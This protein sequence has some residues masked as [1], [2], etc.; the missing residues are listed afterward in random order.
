M[1]N[2]SLL[3]NVEQGNLKAVEVLL[4]SGV[5]ASQKNK[6]GQSLIQVAFEKMLELQYSDKLSFHKYQKIFNLLCQYGDEN[7]KKPSIHL[8]IDGYGLL[9]RYVEALKQN[10]DIDWQEFHEKTKECEDV[11]NSAITPETSPF[12]FELMKKNPCLAL[13]ASGKS[14][15]LIEGERGNSQTGHRMH[16]AG[17]VIESL[18]AR[19]DHDMNDNNFIKDDLK[20]KLL[21][22]KRSGKTLHLTGLFS[23]GRIHADAKHLIYIANKANEMGIKVKAHLI[24]DGTDSEKKISVFVDQ[25]QKDIKNHQLTT[26][27]TI[28]G[29][30]HAMDSRFN[31]PEAKKAVTKGYETI[32]N[33][34]TELRANSLDEAVSIHMSKENYQKKHD[35]YLTPTVIGNYTG[36]EEGDMLLCT[37]Y[38]SDYTRELISRFVDGSIIDNSNII[39]M[40]PYSDEISAK[41]I[42]LYTQ[43]KGK[44]SMGEVI[45]NAGLNQIRIAQ[46]KK[47]DHATFFYDIDRDVKF[48]TFKADI[49]SPEI[50]S[51]KSE[52]AK[53]NDI[54]DDCARKVINAIEE[55]STEFIMVN[56][57]AP[58]VLGHTGVL[59]DTKIAVKHFDDRLKD[60]LRVLDKSGGI[61]LISAD[62]GNADLMRELDGA[63]CTRHS[64]NLVPAIVVGKDIHKD[65]FKVNQSSGL[66]IASTGPSLLNLMKKHLGTEVE[67]PQEMINTPLLF[68]PEKHL[69]MNNQDH[70][71]SNYQLAR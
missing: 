31:H 32:S 47:R 63:E 57:A 52:L 35:K 23:D 68:E 54:T 16:G 36:M 20:E 64:G 13:D 71:T 51:G 26:V 3:I 61:G 19:I 38:R 70:K 48:S 18:S 9:P 66:G 1:Y 22:L 59:K 33:G 44:N 29:R 40:G 6:S 17:R 46:P 4:K 24:A 45:A 2:S 5:K 21:S 43:E 69:S 10:P 12:M 37:N 34:N 8:I 55:D 53:Q 56:F 25:F 11:K 39:G 27:A 58:D 15:G 67:I 41:I 49:V 65:K 7:H 28:C 50:G 62:H 30:A 42:T 14:A 60:V